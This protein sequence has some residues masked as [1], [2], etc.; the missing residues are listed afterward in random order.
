MALHIDAFDQLSDSQFF[1]NQIDPYQT[2]NLHF[3]PS[4]PVVRRL[5]RAMAEE[6]VRVDDPWAEEQVLAHLLPYD[7]F[8]PVGINK[9]FS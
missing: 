9:E 4:D 7:L 3:D 2:N 8:A 5:L 1:D 6:L